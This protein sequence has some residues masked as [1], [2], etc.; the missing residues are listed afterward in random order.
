MLNLLYACI[1]KQTQKGW[2]HFRFSSR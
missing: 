1:L 2:R